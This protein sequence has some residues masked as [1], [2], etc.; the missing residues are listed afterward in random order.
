[1]GRIRRT[2]ITTYS[3]VTINLLACKYR[4]QWVVGEYFA[5]SIMLCSFE[6]SDK[7]AKMYD[8]QFVDFNVTANADVDSY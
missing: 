1:M 2:T 7:R 5:T 8:L 4:E 3:V 6:C